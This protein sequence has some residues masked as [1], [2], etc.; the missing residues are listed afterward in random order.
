MFVTVFQWFEPKNLALRTVRVE[1]NSMQQQEAKV[2]SFLLDVPFCKRKIGVLPNLLDV[3]HKLYCDTP[4]VL[5]I[6]LSNINSIEE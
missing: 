2:P 6:D 1:T 5:L 3:V 4:F